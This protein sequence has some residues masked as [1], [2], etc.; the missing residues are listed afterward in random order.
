MGE[1]AFAQWLK[2]ALEESNKAPWE[3]PGSK[4]PEDYSW[5]E[6]E[7]LTGAQQIAFQTY[8]GEEAFAQWL[9][10]A[11]EESER[12]PWEV[13]GAQQPQDYPWEEFE[14]LTGAQQIAFQKYLG[15]EAFES[16][17]NRVLGL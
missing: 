10:K 12:N 4:Q 3:K 9:E 2:K 1:E 5:K 8:L 17:L 15:E 16:W 7:A 14:A 6:F 13:P 11:L